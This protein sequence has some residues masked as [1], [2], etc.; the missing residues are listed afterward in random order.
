MDFVHLSAQ[1]ARGRGVVGEGGRPLG[2]PHARAA[3][4]APRSARRA[5]QRASRRAAARV[6]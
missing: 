1:A 5:A 4:V 2:P 3:R 6:A